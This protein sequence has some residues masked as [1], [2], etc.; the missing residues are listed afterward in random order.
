MTGWEMPG[1]CAAAILAFETAIAKASW[2]LTER[3]DPEKT[4]HP[5]AVA[6]LT[7]V[8][9]F[10]WRRFLREAELEQIP[11]DFTHSLHA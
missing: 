5:M 4:Y 10:P 1:E 9:P 11:I 8:A 6:H 2:A 7:Q 3:R